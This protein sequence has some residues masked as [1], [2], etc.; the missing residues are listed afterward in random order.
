MN[1]ME[2][3]GSWTRE[4]AVEGCRIISRDWRRFRDDESL[5]STTKVYFA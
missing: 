2:L 4:C 3:Q 1:G 5:L